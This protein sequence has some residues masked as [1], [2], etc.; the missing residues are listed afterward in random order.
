MDGI[1]AEVDLTYDKVK[2]FCRLCGLFIH[3]V[4]GSDHLIQ[5]EREALKAPPEEA[6]SHLSL[7]SKSIGRAAPKAKVARVLSPTNSHSQRSAKVHVTAV[8]QNTVPAKVL[9][10]A[11]K[12][13]PTVRK[14]VV[15]IGTT[16]EV[17]PMLLD[18][19]VPN[20]IISKKRSGVECERT[21]KRYLKFPE[22]SLDI[23]KLGR[24]F[25]SKNHSK[26]ELELAAAAQP[27]KWKSHKK[28]NSSGN[29]GSKEAPSS[30]E[31]VIKNPAEVSD[32]ADFEMVT[33]KGSTLT[34]ELRKETDGSQAPVVR[35]IESILPP[36][37]EGSASGTPN[38][39]KI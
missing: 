14:E 7:F 38:S 39:E 24:P 20:K 16:S 8:T 2:G 34:S 3:D 22:P 29:K 18:K 13:G 1:V 15:A 25:G 37:A 4:M 21:E 23:K 35:V 10:G 19:V 27:K 6:M 12:T 28:T 5:K 36:I 26:E 17:I 32:K 11:E 30:D 9:I 33:F 31:G